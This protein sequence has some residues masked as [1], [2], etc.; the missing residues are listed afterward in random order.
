MKL[1]LIRHGLT[2]A[3]EQH[4]YCGWSD[5]PLSEK[6]VRALKEKHYGVPE[7][8]RYITSGMRR[9]NQTLRLL[10]GDVN[11]TVDERLKEINFGIFELKSYEQ[12]KDDAQYQRWI[13][14]D[15]DSNVAPG[16]E[17]ANI[18][19][20]RVINAAEEIL[21][22]E[23]DTVAVT[24]GGVIAVIMEQLFAQDNKNRYQWQ[25]RPGRG[26]AVTEEGFREI[27]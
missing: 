18:F 15:N 3:N 4:L 13:S 6:G 17:S 26:Y 7:N 12:L 5:I 2:E 23:T 1:Y 19:K 16:G 14:G 8:C 24:H 20:S 22:S 27:P 25:P 10:F 11:Y 9:T 21:S